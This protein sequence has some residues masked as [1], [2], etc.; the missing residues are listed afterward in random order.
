MNQLWGLSESLVDDKLIPPYTESENL[1]RGQPNWVA[2]IYRIY[3]DRTLQLHGMITTMNRF[4][5]FVLE[6]IQENHMKDPT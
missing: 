2:N 6:I 1:A 5:S 4:D 3:T